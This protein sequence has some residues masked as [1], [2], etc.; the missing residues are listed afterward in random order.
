M[1]APGGKPP[2]ASGFTLIEVVVALAILA[3]ALLAFY[4]FLSSALNAASRVRH[5]AAAYDRSENALAVAA[6]LN[7]MEKP[8]GVFEVGAYRIRWRSEPIGAPRQ[9]TAYPSGKGR[10]LVALY[11]LVLDFPDD[12]DFA[13]VEVTKLGYRLESQPEDML[14]NTAK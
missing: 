5:A 6:T 4:A 1:P 14:G 3:A 13:A 2:P 8:A 7:P 12:R 9:S 10:F 11:R